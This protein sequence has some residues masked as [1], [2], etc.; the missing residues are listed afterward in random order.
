[1]KFK[2]HFIIQIVLFLILFSFF[3]WLALIVFVYHFIPS[4][5][6]ALK[7]IGKEHLHR[8]TFHNIFIAIIASTIAITFLPQTIA[9]ISICNLVLHLLMDLEGKGV[10]LLWPIS[11]KRIILFNH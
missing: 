3:E 1:M 7:K 4:V 11:N 5:D 2:I 8:K 9:L 6:F 10:A